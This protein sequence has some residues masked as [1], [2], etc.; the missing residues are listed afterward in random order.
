MTHTDLALLVYAVTDKY[1]YL[2]KQLAKGHAHTVEYRVNCQML[3]K[4]D[5]AKLPPLYVVS[6]PASY[7][8]SSAWD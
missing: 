4:D 2:S 7:I 6:Q 8:G 5:T 3:A 1:Y